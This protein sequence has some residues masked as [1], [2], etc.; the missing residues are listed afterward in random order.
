MA[1][2]IKDIAKMTKLGYAT[3]SAYLNG[4]TVRPKNKIAIEKA[5]AELGYVRNEYAR[6]LKTRK[7]MTIG[8]LIPE[9]NNTFSTTI[10]SEIEDCLLSKGYGVIVCDCKTDISLEERSLR[11]LMSKMVDGLVIMPINTDGK[12]IDIATDRGI[13]TVVIDRITENK[14]ASYVVINNEE[15]SFEAVNK[16][17]ELGHKNIA[18][19]T[20]NQNIYTARERTNGYKRAL[21]GKNALR[22]DLIFDGLLS[23]EGS[24][25]AMKNIIEKRLDITALFVT[26]YEMTL[27]AIIAINELG[28]KI[29]QDY[30]FIGFDNQELSRIFSPK[31]ATVNQPLKEIGQKAARKLLAIIDGEDTAETIILDAEISEGDSIK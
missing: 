29:P 16:L 25:T 3:I 17:V 12:L 30:S 23:V 1:A 6:G 5:I 20:G 31:L 8:V 28:K 21:E 9:L 15:A 24:Y 22:E 10:I 2:T 14:K 18:L 27:G 4:V 19:I 13:P 7:T 26:N 11:F